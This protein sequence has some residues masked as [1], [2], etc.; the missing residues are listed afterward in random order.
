M[1]RSTISFFSVFISISSTIS[2]RYRIAYVHNYSCPY[3]SR[4]RPYCIDIDLHMFHTKSVNIL[5]QYRQYR[6]NINFS[7]LYKL[8]L[9]CLKSILSILTI[10]CLY[11]F[12]FK[13]N[14]NAPYFNVDI[15]DIISDIDIDWHTYTTKIVHII[16]D[17]VSI[18]I[19][20]CAECN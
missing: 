17:I 2:Y 19:F 13:H 15:V 18:S 12:A 7:F 4:Y 9:P 10:L 16:V 6:I 3:L 20:F 8:G 1:S 14:Y 5:N 11:R